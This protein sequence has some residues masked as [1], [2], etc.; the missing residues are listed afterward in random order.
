MTLR[1]QQYTHSATI[2]MNFVPGAQ[3]AVQGNDFELIPMVKVERGHS[4]EGSFGREFLT[5]YTVS[6][7]NK[8]L[9]YCP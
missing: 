1:L 9:Q 5:I 6:Q 2:W 3:S 4:V 7:K 8:A